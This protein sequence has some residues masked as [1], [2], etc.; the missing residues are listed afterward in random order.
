LP[1]C[2]NVL[3]LHA[4]VRELLAFY[5]FPSKSKS[6]ILYMKMLQLGFTIVVSYISFFFALGVTV[7]G[8][9]GT[10]PADLSTSIVL[11]NERTPSIL[12][13]NC[14][15]NAPSIAQTFVNEINDL[16]DENLHNGTLTLDFSGRDGDPDNSSAVVLLGYLLSSEGDEIRITI[17]E[18]II[19][20]APS[21]MVGD[22]EYWSPEHSYNESQL[23]DFVARVDNLESFRYVDLS[24]EWPETD[25]S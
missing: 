8:S 15:P 16:L 1:L 12:P 11:S 10:R 23:L 17:R 4:G 9:A 20:Q 14:L 5:F 21:P 22:F 25:R 24:D 19:P 13:G 2:S 3:S 18:I 7:R 6:K